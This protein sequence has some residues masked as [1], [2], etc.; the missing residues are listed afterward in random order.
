[1][2]TYTWNTGATSKSSAQF[3]SMASYFSDKANR[4]NYHP[5]YEEDSYVMVFFS[6]SVVLDLL[7]ITDEGPTGDAVGILTNWLWKNGALSFE[8]LGVDENGAPVEGMFESPEG[9]FEGLSETEVVAALQIVQKNDLLRAIGYE[10]ETEDANVNVWYLM[11]GA[12]NY[13]HQAV[14]KNNVYLLGRPCPPYCY[15]S[16]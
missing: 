4:A 2:P 15:D 14:F 12:D 6:G 1:M 5:D 11:D 13:F 3:N 16:E 9:L 8:F 7:G 10:P